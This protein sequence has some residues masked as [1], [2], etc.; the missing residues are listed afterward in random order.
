MIIKVKDCNN[1]PFESHHYDDFSIGAHTWFNCELHSFLK[2]KGSNMISCIRWGD[3]DNFPSCD[4]CENLD[5]G[6]DWNEEK[7]KCDELREQYIKDNLKP[8]L[9]RPDWCPLN[10]DLLIKNIVE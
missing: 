5:G 8:E 3:E 10:Q 1:C 4:Y 2:I 7:C 9:K 6:E